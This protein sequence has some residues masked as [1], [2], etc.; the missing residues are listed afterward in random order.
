MKFEF[1]VKFT[2]EKTRL[3]ARQ[4]EG[5]GEG[6]SEGGKEGVQEKGKYRQN[7]GLKGE[8]GPL[9]IPLPLLL[10]YS[11]SLSFLPPEISLRRK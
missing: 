5:E 1:N 11:L 10:L 2:I 3:G 6:G 9:N 4:R 7:N 8:G